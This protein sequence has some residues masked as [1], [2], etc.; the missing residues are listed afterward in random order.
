MACMA[1]GTVREAIVEALRERQMGPV[2]LLHLV[3][4]RGYSDSEVKQ[5]MSELL[6]DGTIELSTQR[7]LRLSSK[8]AA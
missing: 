3:S 4:D 1:V 8:H 7:V 2:A 5:G 6:N